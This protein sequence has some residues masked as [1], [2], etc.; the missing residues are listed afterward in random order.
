[1]KLVSFNV[2]LKILLLLLSLL[3]LLRMSE[4]KYGGVP[5]KESEYELKKV[6]TS[7]GRLV[8]EKVGEY[9]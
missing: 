8:Q 6:S 1:M 4:G 9:K 5:V 3:L 2:C 7:E